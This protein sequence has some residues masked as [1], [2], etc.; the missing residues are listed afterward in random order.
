VPTENELKYVLEQD[1]EREVKHKATSWFLIHQGYLVASRGVSL[2]VRSSLKIG[3]ET[4]IRYYMTFKYSAK[5]RVI[6]IEKK[7]DER[8]FSE[9]WDAA[10]NK[11]V[12][13][14]YKVK[15]S[16]KHNWEIDFFRDH[17]DKTYFVM[18]E[19]EMPEGQ[20]VPDAIPE[21]VSENLLFPVPLTDTRFSSKLLADVRYAKSL[22]TELRGKAG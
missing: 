4:D 7:I 1:C 15:D 5:G 11:I 2:R 22:Y 14:R 21:V 9:I 10:M 18:A 12:K 19:H 8:D 16:K 17:H 20:T 6:E 13:M 3:E